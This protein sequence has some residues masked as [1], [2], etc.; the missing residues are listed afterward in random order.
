[1]TFMRHCATN[2]ETNDTPP[3][4]TSWEGIDVPIIVPDFT[5][6][7]FDGTWLLLWRSHMIDL[8]MI[9]SCYLLEPTESS[10]L[11]SARLAA[12]GFRNVQDK[13]K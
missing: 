6:T 10:S 1:M 7:Y 9:P 2:M 3:S 5:Q 8:C 13:Q 12:K 11:T 4:P